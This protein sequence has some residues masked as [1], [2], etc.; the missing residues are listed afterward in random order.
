MNRREMIGGVMATGVATLV[1]SGEQAM[2]ETMSV[3][4]NHYYE[5]RTYDLRNDLQP[6]RTNDYF[7][8]ILVPALKRAGAG[9]VGAFSVVSG[10]RTPA[11]LLLIDHSSL[12]TAQATMEK[13]SSDKEL[14]AAT[15]AFDAS[16]LPPYVRYESALLRA[17]DGHPRLE[18]PPTDSRRAPRLFELRTYE[19]RTPTSLRRKIDMFNQEEIKIFRDCGFANVFFGEMLIGPRMPNLTYLVGFDDMATRE[20]AWDTFRVNPDWLRI[21]GRK[22]WADAEV[23]SNITASFLRPTVFSSIR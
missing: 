13:V 6:S 7:E 20:K 10:Q 1:N 23:V 4:T 3:E 11:L 21:K 18:V 8:K 19:S 5:L 15:E 12:A 17:F 2:A 9:T 22:E 14:L 16:G